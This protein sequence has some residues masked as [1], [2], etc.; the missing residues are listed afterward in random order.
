MKK[1]LLLLITTLM[2]AMSANAMDIPDRS[3]YLNGDVTGEGEIDIA[4]VNAVIDVILGIDSNP[5]ADVN[6]DGEVT[7]ADVNVIIDIIFGG[8]APIPHYEYVDLGLPSGTL[9]ATMNVGANRPEDY[10]DYFAWGETEPKEI[11]SWWTYKWGNGSQNKLTKYCT[12]S[13]YG[14]VDNRIFLAQEDDAAYVNWGPSWRIPTEEQQ[15]ELLTNCSWKWTT[16]NGVNGY[17][18]TGPNGNTLFMPAAGY[19]EYSKLYQEG[20]GGLYWSCSLSTGLSCKAEGFQMDEGAVAW[21]YTLGDRFYGESVRAVYVLPTDSL[22]LYIKQQS[23]DFGNVPIGETR[24][25]ELTIV[26]NTTKNQTVTVNTSAPFTFRTGGT[27]INVLVTA[28]SSRSVIV[29]FKASTLGVF[30][31]SVSFQHPIFD[32]AQIIIPVRARAGSE[33]DPEHEYVDLGLPSG[34]LWAT[35]N[36]GANTPEEYGYYFAWG[37][38][39]TKEIYEWSTYKWCNG[40]EN[41]LTKYCT[42]SNCGTVDNKT[43]LDFEDDAAYVN[44]GSSWRMPSMEQQRELVEQC[45]CTWTTLNGV[46]GR[47]FTGPNGNTLFLPAAGYYWPGQLIEVGSYGV[48][49]SRTLRP[50]GSNYAYGLNFTPNIAGWNYGNYR[51]GGRSVRAVRV[52]PLYIEQQSLDLGALSIGETRMGELTIVNNDTEEQ[53]LTV[54]ADAP[55]TLRQGNVS[56]SNITVVVPARSSRPV[57]VLFTAT[58][59]GKFNG[60][61]IFQNSALEGGQRVIPVQASVFS[62][63]EYV[64]LGLPSGTLW[65]TMNVGATAPEDYGDYFA[66]GE[67]EPKEIYTWETYKLCNGSFGTITKYCTDSDFGTVDGK[68]ELEPEDDAATVNWGESWRTPTMEQLQELFW[69]CGSQWTTRNG[70]Y[71]RLFKGSNGNS[72][73]MPVGGYR[74][75]EALTEEGIE[76][77][78]WSRMLYAHIPDGANCMS[79]DSQYKTSHMGYDRIRGLS[80]RPVRV[81]PLDI[82]PRSLDFGELTIGNTSTRELTIINNTD[83]DQT[84]TVTADAPFSMKQDE[85]VASSITIVV[86]SKSNRSVTALFTATEPGEFNGNVTFHNPAM[87][88][89]QMAIPARGGAFSN[90]VPEYVDLGLSSGTLWA[91]V[92]VGASKPEEYGDYFAWGETKSKEIYTWES[93]KWY[94]DAYGTITK[95]CTD[96]YYGTVD[97][98]TELDPKD[99]A[100]TVNWG[101]EWCMP[102]TELQEELYLECSSKWTTLNGVKGHLFVGP[103]GNTLFLPAAGYRSGEAIYGEGAFGSFWASTG[104]NHSACEIGFN[105]GSLFLNGY[106]SDRYYG[107]SIRAVRAQSFYFEQQS[108]ELGHVPIGETHRSELT[109][110]NMTSKDQTL[111]VTVDEPFLLRQ[112]SSGAS[113]ITI[114]VPSKSKGS[115]TVMFTATTPGEFN[116]NITFQNP[117]FD[118]GQSAIPVKAR[119]YI[120]QDVTQHEY[121]DLG[122]PS[123]TLWAT[124][125]I[126]AINPEDYGDYFAWGETEPKEI[127][128]WATY[129]TGSGQDAA[130]IL[131]GPEWRMP[132]QEQQLELTTKCFWEWTSRN[133][134]YGQLITGPNGNT[135]FL[136]AGGYRKNDLICCV[137]LEGYFWL[138]TLKTSN[139][140]YCLCFGS[141]W[142]GIS[143]WDECYLGYTIRPVRISSGSSLSPVIEQQ[144]IEPGDVPTT[145]ASA[146]ELTIFNHIPNEQELDGQRRSIYQATSRK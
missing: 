5:R 35:C 101:K 22:Q 53:T 140:A 20:T 73:F 86:P 143:H 47:L 37:E 79:F 132:S 129:N 40:S 39:E 127:Y 122:L 54:T 65:A 17:K 44:W 23:L 78:Y 30:N 61:I 109:I 51:Y 48:C 69:Y 107:H 118:G 36:V 42:N 134:V 94:D 12:S 29:K 81:L 98:K 74:S 8:T 119:A 6:Y 11:Y 64:D 26:N 128:T 63:D 25:G 38:T 19:R 56:A 66:W 28:G 50:D 123:G 24:T 88:E 41:T 106:Y 120:R 76:G 31:G 114:M 102:T 55:F 126:G 99:D 14:T 21:S 72:I 15:L 45:S 7:V 137:G 130:H 62:Y 67:T 33:D 141:N 71:G 142:R 145:E 133:G 124:C 18:V 93:Y 89:G 108:L 85:G 92:N 121:I 103:N 117:A 97:G 60:N 32:G 46:N 34:T 110:V 80:V 90:D 77:Y 82:Q 146:R 75:G 104:S 3:R 13:S 138:R 1:S 115:V 111:T 57:T 27:S 58:E 135:I 144:S 136:P 68:T 116:G 131:W 10:G 2:V 83:E 96:S 91:T 70:V 43:E 113:S 112:G 9:W 52:W 105:S 49:W 87:V 16:R 4:D 125:N 100:A 95:Y 84:V 139:S 59:A